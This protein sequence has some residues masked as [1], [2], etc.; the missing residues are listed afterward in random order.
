MANV[1][2]LD[3]LVE[4]TVDDSMEKIVE[5][6]TAGRRM[7]FNPDPA[8]FKQLAAG[9]LAKLSE[10]GKFSYQIARDEWQEL[11]D[12]ER[13]EEED[14]LSR[15]EVGASMGRATQRLEIRGKQKGIEYH[16]FRPDERN[17]VESPNVGWKPVVGG[18]E[19][20]LSNDTGK[21][22]HVIGTKGSEELI[23]FKRPESARLAERRAKK[24][25]RRQEMKDADARYREEIERQGIT[26]IGDEDGG[27][28]H[29]RD[30]TPETDE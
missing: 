22:P 30:R 24:N 15:I 21:G 5:L 29:W 3:Q 4:I 16:W 26:A 12:A 10:F 7:R 1:G 9:D 17:R 19:R 2:K 11:K 20:T 28:A 13:A 23:L 14:L 8:K 27:N 18:P 25:L 6:D